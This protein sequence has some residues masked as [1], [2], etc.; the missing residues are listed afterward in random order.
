MIHMLKHIALF[1]HSDFTWQPGSHRKNKGQHHKRHRQ[2]TPYSQQE[3]DARAPHAAA[4]CS[5]LSLTAALQELRHAIIRAPAAKRPRWQRLLH[6]RLPQLS[7]LT[8]L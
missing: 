2:D 1:S 3:Q 6:L 4:R 7:C 8:S 5:S